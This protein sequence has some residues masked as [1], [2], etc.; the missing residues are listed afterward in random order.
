MDLYNRDEVLQ[1]E[2]QENLEDQS[3]FDE[4]SFL[5]DIKKKI[6]D[7]KELKEQWAK[8]VD[9][10]VKHKWI[11]RYIDDKQKIQLEKHYAVLCD[12]KTNYSKYKQSFKFIAKFMGLPNDNIIIE[13]MIFTKDK[14]DKEQW[15]IS[16]K[17]SKGLA[18]VFIPE[19]VRLIHVSPVQGIKDL[20]PSFRSKTKG[21]Y[22]YPNKRIFF[23]VAKDIKPTQA[24][25]EGQKTSRYTPKE[26][27]REAYIDPTYADFSSGAVY[28][29]TDNP[30]P[31]ETLESKWSK[32]F[33]KK[34][35]ENSNAE[36][37]GTK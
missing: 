13:N 16:I 3:I 28:V 30:I 7:T 34:E 8:V 10:F 27:I 2:S 12:E 21:K 20:I 9:K 6:T 37:E 14:E 19:G 18:K 15:E 11:Y 33:K 31:V 22:M 25:L 35:K 17:Y 26:E 24:G 36:E 5:N 23:T 1:R 29:E 32:I 4:V